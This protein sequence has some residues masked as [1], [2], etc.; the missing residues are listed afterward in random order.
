[1]TNL[2]SHV[3]RLTGSTDLVT[4]T[5]YKCGV[6]FAMTEDYWERRHRRQDT[7]H[8]PNGHPQAYQGKT[9]TEKLKDAKAREVALQ[10][11]LGAAVREAEAARAA[12]IRDRHRFAN[13]VCPCCNRSFENVRRHMS[14][15]H[16]DYDVTKVA[17]GKAPRYRCSC[18]RHFETPRGLA[19]HQG[20]ARSTGWEASKSAWSQHLTRT[21]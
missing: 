9:D 8:C 17:L 1:M 20:R 6:L 16:P 2:R 12:L 11:Q 10:D 7:F 19:I 5:C 13:G 14:T 3:L 18:G 21:S 4:E 15:Q